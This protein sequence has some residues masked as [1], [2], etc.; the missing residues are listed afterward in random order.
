MKRGWI[1]ALAAA[2]LFPA[3]SAVTATAEEKDFIEND[4]LNDLEYYTEHFEAYKNANWRFCFGEINDFY[5]MSYFAPQRSWVGTE[6][7]CEIANGIL[8]TGT[9]EMVIIVWTAPYGGT[10]SF[11]ASSQKKYHD[12][13]DGSAM[14]IYNHEKELLDEEYMNVG[15][16]EIKTYSDSYAVSAG[17]SV[18]FVLDYVGNN[19]TD[20][21]VFDIRIKLA[22]LV[23]EKETEK[24]CGASL[25]G[26][27][28]SLC[29]LV[30]P[31]FLI[32]K[33]RG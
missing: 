32:K 2:V 30:P 1:L 10:L 17:D 19:W 22:D 15:D 14:L 12:N 20:S 11:T 13:G 9:N 3:F 33:R 8:H 26:I 29:L 7:Y 4:F 25:A 23:G 27:G 31:V 5:D 21:T 6:A 28:G 16:S 24:G 18:Y